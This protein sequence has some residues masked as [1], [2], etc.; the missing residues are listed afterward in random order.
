M[1]V[2]P[3]LKG[4]LG[5]WLLLLMHPPKKGK[6]KKK[7]Q[8]VASIVWGIVEHLDLI[9]SGSGSYEEGRRGRGIIVGQS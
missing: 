6:K 1:L 8:L 4:V 5:L 2:A 7:P 3:D 9:V